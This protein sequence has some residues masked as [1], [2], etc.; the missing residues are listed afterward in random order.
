M[1]ESL[2]CILILLTTDTILCTSLA[3]PLGKRI[4][5]AHTSMVSVK[6]DIDFQ[7]GLLL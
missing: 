3:D 6:M 4:L 5:H 1:L 2:N 7:K